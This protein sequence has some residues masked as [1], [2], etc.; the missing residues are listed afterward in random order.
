[1]TESNGN[2]KGR[3]DFR[4][5]S[6]LIMVAMVPM[7]IVTW[8]LFGNYE[9]A[10]LEMVGTNLSDTSETAFSLINSNLQN[11]IIAVAGLAESPVLRGVIAERNLDLKRNLEEVRKEIP[12][13]A[14]AWPTLGRESPQVKSIVDNPA[15]KFLRRYAA[16]N[17][18]YRDI[19]VTDFLGRLVAATG[20]STAYYYAHDE[21]WKEA[22]GDGQRGSVY[23]GDARFDPAAKSYLLDLAQPF[24]EPDLGVVGV[25]KIV[26]DLQ[27]IHSL[28][29]SMQA[30]TGR[31]VGLIHARG[32]VISAPGYSSLQQITYPAT[33]D[34]LNAR[35]KARRYFLTST[36]PESMYGLARRDFTQLYPHLNWIVFTTGKV[37]DLKGP[38][39]Q[40]R[41]Y[42]MAI[43]VGTFLLVLI[44]TVM[45]SMVESKPVLEEDPHLERL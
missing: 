27:G 5:F 45:L 43:V 33:L 35:E 21:W 34:I 6:I 22:Y 25:I 40:L 3:F 31:S 23:I 15:S 16:I 1:M 44:A 17:Q 2:S 7:L 41:K 20:K 29:G 19:M 28:V 14:D 11:Q 26:L 39:P 8:Y 10:Y 12:R 36:A 13:M 32:D 38:L 37:A 4:T 24:V 18:P 30:G 9:E 42:F